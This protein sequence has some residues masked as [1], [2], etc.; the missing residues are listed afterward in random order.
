[1]SSSVDFGT[2][3]RDLTVDSRSPNLRGSTVLSHETPDNAY[4]LEPDG[5]SMRRS[6]AG[7]IHWPSEEEAHSLLSSVVSSI[8]SVQHLIDP[9][10]FS[11]RL[12]SFYEDE[13][14][15]NYAIDLSHVEM[16]MVFA[17]GG[18]LQGKLKEG[19]TFPGA[20]YFLEAVNNL[21]SLCTLRKAD[22][23]AIEVMGLVAFFL[24]CSDRK[25][26]AYVYV[27]CTP[28]SRQACY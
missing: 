20:E 5:T 13:S 14:C 12:S 10:S 19:S 25:D 17:L 26:D 3:I 24:Q 18:L 21:P 28:H 8:G 11:D 15:K 9:R 1:M 27:S 22:V 2:R 6:R 16:L 7:D 23:L 4:E